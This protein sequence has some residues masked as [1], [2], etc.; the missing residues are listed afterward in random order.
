MSQIVDKPAIELKETKAEKFVRLGD[1]RAL[2]IAKLFR[3]IGKLSNKSAYD[4][5]PEQ[6]E[7]LFKFIDATCQAAKDKFFPPEKPAEQKFSLKTYVDMGA[8]EGDKTIYRAGDLPDM[9]NAN[10]SQST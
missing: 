1:A 6:A 7:Q 3:S 5:T 2:R 8:P 10:K 4:F 9:G